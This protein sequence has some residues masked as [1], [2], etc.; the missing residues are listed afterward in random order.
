MSGF[1]LGKYND[2]IEQYGVEMVE[3]PTIKYHL[4][5]VSEDSSNAVTTIIKKY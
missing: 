5:Q 2:D 3:E 4:D 1:F